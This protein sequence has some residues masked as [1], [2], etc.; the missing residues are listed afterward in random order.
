MNFQVSLAAPDIQPF[1]SL[2]KTG[3]GVIR[4]N[5]GSPLEFAYSLAKMNIKTW[6]DLE[7]NIHE[8]AE[9]WRCALEIV[10]T[11]SRRY[12]LGSRWMPAKRTIE[13]NLKKMES[14]TDNV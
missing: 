4:L 6:Y 2:D 8:M 13:T 10:D 11:L 1:S 12:D 9:F 5:T 7:D 3:S 14:C